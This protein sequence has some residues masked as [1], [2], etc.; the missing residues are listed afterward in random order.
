MSTRRSGSRFYLLTA[1]HALPVFTISPSGGVVY[2]RRSGVRFVEYWFDPT[3]S[4]NV[5]NAFLQTL[6]GLYEYAK[7]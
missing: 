2:R 1:R 5:I 4:D 6:L 3:H 7:A